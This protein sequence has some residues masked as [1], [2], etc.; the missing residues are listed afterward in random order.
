LLAHRATRPPVDNI[1]MTRRAIFWTAI[2][3]SIALNACL[4]AANFTGLIPPAS[5][6]GKVL[7]SVWIPGAVLMWILS[8]VLPIGHSIAQ[9]YVSMAGSIAIHAAAIWALLRYFRSKR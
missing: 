2:G 9:L 6:L 3:A 5:A 4:T 7:Y 1:P 8:L